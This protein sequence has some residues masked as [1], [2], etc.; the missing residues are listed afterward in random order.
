MREI[1]WVQ[2]YLRMMTRMRMERA[3]AQ[4]GRGL[5]DRVQVYIMFYSVAF[6]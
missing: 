5:V 1:A 3:G 6:L 2:I 4:E